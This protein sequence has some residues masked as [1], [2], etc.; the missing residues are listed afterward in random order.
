MTCCARVIS[1]DST[2]GPAPGEAQFLPAVEYIR[3][4]RVRTLLMEKMKTLFEQVDLYVGGNDLVITNLTGHPT[5]V[6]PN[7]FRTRD[8][9][10]V[11]TSITFTGNLFHESDLLTLAHAYQQATGFICGIHRSNQPR[12]VR[13]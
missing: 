10:E 3:A 13:R 1:K 4:N 11:P 8:G 5:V 6:M 7:G 12:T 9:R 2:S